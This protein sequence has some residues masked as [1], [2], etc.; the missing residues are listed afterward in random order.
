MFEAFAGFI[1]GIAITIF[2]LGSIYD[3]NDRARRVECQAKLNVTKC[4]RTIE[5]V[6]DT[7][8]K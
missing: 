4:V 3:V 2:A 1:I 5:Y 8:Q 7:G 6:A